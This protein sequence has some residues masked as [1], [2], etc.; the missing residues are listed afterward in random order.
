MGN[1]DAG[2][3]CD[4]DKVRGDRRVVRARRDLAAC[5]SRRQSAVQAALDKIKPVSASQPVAAEAL[6]KERETVAAR[7]GIV[8]KTEAKVATDD[9]TWQ[10]DVEEQ[11]VHVLSYP[12]EAQ[13]VEF[14]VWF[15]RPLE[16]ACLEQ[17]QASASFASAAAFWKCAACRM[18]RNRAVNE[19][20]CKCGAARGSTRKAHGETLA[21]A[22]AQSVLLDDMSTS[23]QV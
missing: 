16:R 11:G 15:T 3:A 22:V 5:S 10:L 7:G 1:A 18:P 19:F 12:S 21:E 9:H 23:Y 4:H 6:R 8:A 2:G 13:V 20:C 17:Q 14:A